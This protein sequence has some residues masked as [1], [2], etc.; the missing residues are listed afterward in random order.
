MTSNLGSEY[1]IQDPD[2]GETTV[3]QLVKRTFKPEFLNRI[4][5]II[6]FKPLSYDT[7]VK[8]VQK[9]LR[10]LKDRLSSQNIMISFDSSVEKAIIEQA[11]DPDYGARP[12]KR[13]IQRYVETDIA[14]FIINQSVLPNHS[15]R[16]A[17]ENNSFNIKID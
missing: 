7:Q 4:D 15:Y 1:L 8:I 3:L 5:E 9:L 11:F 2:Q 13:Y 16:M 6:V 17:Y 12:I 14:R 10:E